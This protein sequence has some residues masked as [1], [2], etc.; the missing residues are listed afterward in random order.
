MSTYITM[1]FE[2]WLLWI[3]CSFED[4]S[5]YECSSFCFL[6]LPGLGLL[7]FYQDWG[8]VNFTPP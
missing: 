4:G 8:G 7:S 1:Q 2:N 3:T 6:T 5:S